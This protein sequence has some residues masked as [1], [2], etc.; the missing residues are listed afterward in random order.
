MG[1]VDETFLSDVQQSWNKILYKKGKI[2][3]LKIVSIKEKNDMK[4]ELVVVTTTKISLVIT[5]YYFLNKWKAI[6]KK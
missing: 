5:Y 6:C 2:I 4:R 3:V 1:D